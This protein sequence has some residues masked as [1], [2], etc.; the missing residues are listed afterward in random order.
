M[1]VAYWTITAS[2]LGELWLTADDAGLT[3]LYM[4][5]P[6]VL[7]DTAVEWVEDDGPFTAV[8]TQLD[9]YFA[10]ELQEFD[11]PLH[12]SGTP[13]Q[14]QVWEALTEIPYG[15]VRSY[16][17]IAEAIGRP[18]A[19][20]AVGM[21]NGRNPVSVI[22]PCHRVIGASGALTGYGWGLD[23]KRALLDLEVKVAGNTLV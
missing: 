11:I 9:A 17:D 14:L 3:G 4:E 7:D 13:F 10:G 2:P 1:T 18:T 22:V 23:R 21:A 15:E 19:S 8:R 16:R 12:M 20:R 5:R 6:H